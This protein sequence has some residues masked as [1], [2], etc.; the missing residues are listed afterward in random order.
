MRFLAKVKCALDWL[1]K[2]FFV[3]T[4]C[5]CCG[6][7]NETVSKRGKYGTLCDECNKHMYP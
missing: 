1:D 6:T 4:D 7:R 3:W 5:E 2:W